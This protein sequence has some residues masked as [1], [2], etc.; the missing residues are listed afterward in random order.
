MWWRLLGHRGGRNPAVALMELTVWKAIDWSS[1]QKEKKHCSREATGRGGLDCRW[2]IQGIG[3]TTEVE[4]AWSGEDV[5]SVGTE[6]GTVQ[7]KGERCSGPSPREPSG[8]GQ[9]ENQKLWAE[10]L[11]SRSPLAIIRRS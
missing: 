3:K 11:R 4:M 1:E 5:V 6:T 10:V 7:E 9:E 2:I 8:Q